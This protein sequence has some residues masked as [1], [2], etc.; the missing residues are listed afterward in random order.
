MPLRDIKIQ[1]S[2]TPRNSSLSLKLYLND[3]SKYNHSDKDMDDLTKTIKQGGKEGLKARNTLVKDNLRFVVSVAK[4]YQGRGLSLDDLIDEGNIGL[5]VAADKYDSSYGVKFLSY[6]VWWIR[7][8]IMSA[9]KRHGNVLHVSNDRVDE[10]IRM[11]RIISDYLTRYGREP[12]D[13]EIAEIMGFKKTYHVK[14]L[15]EITANAVSL[16]SPVTDDDTT[17]LSDKLSSNVYSAPDQKIS[18]DGKKQEIYKILKA[19]LPSRSLDIVSR[20][21][22][23]GRCAESVGAIA[24]QLGITD[25]RVRQILDQSLRFL[26]YG[27]SKNYLKSIDA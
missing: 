23:I 25:A 14:M 11:K 7:Q 22:G 21:Y 17:S 20:Y 1:N 16:D 4:L 24:L 10:I 5:I 8:Y 6:A 15:R 19:Y 26:K 12:S 3:I 27:K 18:S 13:Y 2:I 9:V